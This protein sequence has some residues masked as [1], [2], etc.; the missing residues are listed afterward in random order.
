MKILNN[1]P[2]ASVEAIVGKTS[3]AGTPKKYFELF[4][5]SKTN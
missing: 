3:T 4:D 2:G 1:L 5:Y